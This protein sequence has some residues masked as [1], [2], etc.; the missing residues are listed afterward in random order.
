MKTCTGMLLR[1]DCVREQVLCAYQLHSGSICS[2][3]VGEGVVITGGEDSRLRVWPLHFDDF[4]MEAHHESPVTHVNI[5]GE[6]GKFLSVGTVS[7]TLGV[8][9]VFEHR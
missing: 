6:G 8:L 7:G 9:N 4:L 2:L 1:I 3:A 5:S